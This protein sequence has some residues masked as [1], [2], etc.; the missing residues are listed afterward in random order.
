[1]YSKGIP[2]V[3]AQ[4]RNGYK[5]YNLAVGDTVTD[6]VVRRSYPEND[7]TITGEIAGISLKVKGSPENHAAAVLDNIPAMQGE[8][9][10]CALII[11][12]EV[13]Y[14]VEALLIKTETPVAEGDPIVNYTRIPVGAIYSFSEEPDE[15]I[16]ELIALN[17]VDGT[18]GVTPVTT[19]AVDQTLNANI[20]CSDKEIGV[21]PVDPTAHYKWYYKD[22][23]DTEL[24]TDPTYTFTSDNVGHVIC[25]EVTVDNYTGKL[26]WESAE[27]AEPVW[28][29]N[30]D[31]TIV[32]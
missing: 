8:F 19:P 3:S 17:V 1:M 23:A 32:I 21:Y 2:V 11:D 29:A 6:M 25:L 31:V 13:A 14:E 16:Q 28:P 27:V 7:F 22:S 20:V 18:D 24:G 9:D 5:V 15:V 26:V 10:D 12:A 4:I 30:G